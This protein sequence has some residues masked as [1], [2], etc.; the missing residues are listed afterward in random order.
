MPH[1][2]VTLGTGRSPE[3]VRELMAQLHA[4]VEKAIAAP[5]QGTPLFGVRA[6]R[7]FV[8]SR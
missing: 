7:A 3:Q 8:A 1:I 4:A 5:A 6:A 2:E